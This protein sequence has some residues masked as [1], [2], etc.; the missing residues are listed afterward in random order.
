MTLESVSALA[1]RDDSFPAPS[2]SIG[3]DAVVLFKSATEGFVS[4]STEGLLSGSKEGAAFLLA[5]SE[6]IVLLL[7]FGIDFLRRTRRRR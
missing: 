7:C 3:L 6:D 4:G 2:L 1:E 5:K